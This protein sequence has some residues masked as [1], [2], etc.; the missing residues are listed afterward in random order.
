MQLFTIKE[1]QSL[2]SAASSTAVQPNVT[3]FLPGREAVLVVDT[4]GMTGGTSP[5]FKVEGSDDGT[6]YAALLTVTA[7]KPVQMK[8]IVVP[9][10]LR[11]TVT[12]VSS[13]GTVNAYL[14]GGV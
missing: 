4:D 5:S 7:Q 2:T 1:A 14:L 10:Y 6:T 3:P 11:V 9:N 13:A 8:A 12:S